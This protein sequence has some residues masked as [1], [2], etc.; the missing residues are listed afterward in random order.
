MAIS[1]ISNAAIATV[2]PYQT[3]DT[4]AQQ[5]AQRAQETNTQPQQQ[6]AQTVEPLPQ[7]QRVNPPNL[8]QKV[9]FFA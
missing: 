5:A 4:A 7:P 2:L 8:G 3:N 1:A 6:A 9:D